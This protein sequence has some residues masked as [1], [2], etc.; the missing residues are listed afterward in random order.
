MITPLELCPTIMTS[1]RASYLRTLRI[2]WMWV[3]RPT[4][5]LA[6]CERSPSPVSVG[7]YRPQLARVA[8]GAVQVVL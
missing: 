7:V 2:S 3:S 5:G 1:L 6:K 4:S 8:L